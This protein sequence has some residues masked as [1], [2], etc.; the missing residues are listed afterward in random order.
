MVFILDFDFTAT[1]SLASGLSGLGDAFTM[2]LVYIY[3]FRMY[4]VIHDVDILMLQFNDRKPCYFDGSKNNM[5][6]KDET[7]LL[8]AVWFRSKYSVN[9]LR[10]LLIVFGLTMIIVVV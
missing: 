6:G 4:G 2:L 1:T 8:R 5:N 10:L 9:C 7:I 3:V